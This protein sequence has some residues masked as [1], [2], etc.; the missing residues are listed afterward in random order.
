MIVPLTLGDFLERAEIVY[1]DRE[2]VV[3]EPNPPGGGLGRFTYA[4]S[5]EMA[6]SLAAA[7]DDLGVVENERVAIVS[8][9]AARF[10]LSLFGVS[11]YGRILVPVNFRL[12]PEEIRYILEHSGA[13]VLL[14]DPEL[15]APLRA[16]PVKHRVVLGAATDAQWF[17]RT[18]ARPRLRTADEH[19]TASINYTSGTTARPNGVRR[20]HRN[21]LLSA[22]TFGWHLCLTDRDAHAPTLPTVPC[23]GA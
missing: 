6:R 20:T 11:V 12:N 2:A 5:G 14:V 17:L 1:G 22:V 10:L 15:D 13:S 7:L 16:M 8:P 23:T 21:F 19:A 3:D 18:G 9:N 4:Q